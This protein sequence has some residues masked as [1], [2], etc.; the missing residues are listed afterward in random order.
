MEHALRTYRRNRGISLEHLAASAGTTKATL[1]RIELGRQMP[2][3]G[4]IAKLR[5]ATGGAVSADDFVPQAEGR[6]A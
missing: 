4:L 2:S 6:A 5:D 3:A 1:S